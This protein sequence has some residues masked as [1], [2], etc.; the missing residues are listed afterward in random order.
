MRARLG[1]RGASNA[2]QR[3]CLGQVAKAFGRCVSPKVDNYK[4]PVIGSGMLRE[5]LR[6][7]SAPEMSDDVWGLHRSKT[8]PHLWL[9]HMLVGRSIQPCWGA[10]YL[11]PVER[12]IH[13]DYNL[14]I[15]LY[16]EFV[17]SKPI[18]AR[19]RGAAS[20]RFS[21]RR[22]RHVLGVTAMNAIVAVCAK[23]RCWEDPA[24]IRCLPFA[25]SVLLH[26]LVRVIRLR[27]R[28]SLVAFHTCAA[29]SGRWFREWQAPSIAA[30]ILPIHTT[31][32]EGDQR[33][34]G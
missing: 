21:C 2:M 16:S 33:I 24:F 28:H 15:Q 11:M 3:E 14:Y 5:G 23:T 32:W 18:E 31:A 13:Q 1:C 34:S 19:V 26:D 25:F 22:R 20:V 4:C 7:Q 17:K 10:S 29:G 27:P 12:G 9:W 6:P 8:A 30:N